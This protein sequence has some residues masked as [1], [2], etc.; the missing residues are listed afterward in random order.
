MSFGSG[1]LGLYLSIRALLYKVVINVHMSMRYLL[2]R[3]I[4]CLGDCNCSLG[5]NILASRT[6]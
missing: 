5:W 4:C 6:F 2:K 1:S 3:R